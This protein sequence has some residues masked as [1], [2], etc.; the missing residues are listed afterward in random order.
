[1]REVLRIIEA[2]SGHIELDI[3]IDLR[4]D[5]ARAQTRIQH[6]GRGSWRYRL[7]NEILILASDVEL[8]RR[9]GVLHGSIRS[10]AGD[11]IRLSLGY[12]KDDIGVLPVLLG[13]AADD[14]LT[15]WIARRILCAERKG[16]HRFGRSPWQLRCWRRVRH[17]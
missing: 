6:G 16:L 13:W 14:R 17:R 10:R 3:A 5:Y 11:R 1:M 7:S 9:A 12:V 8:K 4:P 15:P 2:I